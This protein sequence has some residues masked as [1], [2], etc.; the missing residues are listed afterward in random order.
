MR[1]RSVEVLERVLANRSALSIQELAEEYG[2]SEKTLRNDVKEINQF[3]EET[4]LPDLIITKEGSLIKARNFNSREAEKRLYELDAYSYKLSGAER[5]NYISMVL[6]E[7]GRYMTM[8]GFADELHVSRIT[9]VNDMEPV[10]EKMTRFGVDLVLDP[11]KGMVVQCQEPDCLRM[12]A[13]IGY[14]IRDERFFQSFL[15][16]RLEVRYP[17]ESV[18]SSAQAYMRENKLL[19][20][21]DMYYRIA[22]YIFILFNFSS[23]RGSLMDGSSALSDMDTMMLAAA[24]DLQVIVTQQMLDAY[25]AYIRANE[26]NVYLKSVDD[27]VLY[28]VII[29]FLSEIDKTLNMGLANDTMLLDALLMHI[30]NMQNWEEFDVELPV[31]EASS[32]KY[33]LLLKLVDEN[34]GILENYLVHTLSESLKKSIVI[35][36]CVAIIRGQHYMVPVSILLVCPGSRASGKYLEAQIQNYF[37]FQIRAVLTE[38]KEIRR[39]EEREESVDF[40]LSTIPLKTEKYTVYQIHPHLGI[41]DLNLLQRVIFQRQHFQP[42]TKNK[43]EAALRKFI[44]QI[45]DDKELARRLAEGTEAIIGDY[46]EELAKKNRTPLSARLSREYIRLLEK[47]LDWRSAIRTSAAPLLE[48]GFIE[49]DYVD[50][51]IQVVEEYGDYIVVSEG[52]ALAHANQSEG[53]VHRDGLSLLICP[54]GI[55]FTESDQMV[56]LLFCFASTGEQDDLEM[57]KAIIRLG[58]TPGE[59]R[60]IAALRDPDTVYTS[61]LT[62]T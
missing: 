18:L 9:I 36:L 11:G 30:R 41:E 44:Y 13:D 8:Q 24:R 59:A 45:F 1:K 7:S 54:E 51:A 31:E 52:V 61:I 49:P 35:H 55:H 50:R 23:K 25:R 19:F 29:E 43:K 28:K 48:G 17:L 20:V 56:Y 62:A 22:V 14:E 40:V 60:R 6:L 38:E 26:E 42:D 12:M 33:N 47:S 32:I 53:G 34:A 15:Y 3:L 5:Q 10:K 39:I 57:L 46:E 2:T 4:G 16:R 27:I 58:Q 21:G 37:D